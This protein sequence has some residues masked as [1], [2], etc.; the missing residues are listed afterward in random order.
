MARMTISPLLETGVFF[1][2]ELPFTDTE[3]K[4]T[5][6]LKDFLGFLNY[7]FQTPAKLTQTKNLSLADIR[8]INELLTHPLELDMKIGKH[9]YKLR[10]ED[11]TTYIKR[12]NCLA[13]LLHLTYHRK[14]KKYITKGYTGFLKLLPSWQF[15]HLLCAYWSDL[16]WG[17]FHPFQGYN[18]K[19]I[20]EVLQEVRP[21]LRQI[22]LTEACNWV[23]FE[24][25]AK[26]LA[27][28]FNLS[29]HDITGKNQEDLVSWQIETIVIRDFSLFNLIEKKTKK[30]E[31]GF[32]KVQSFHLTKLGQKVLGI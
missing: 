27:R 29:Y 4:N 9:L 15:F 2:S 17:Y 32:D 20:P 21:Y 7:L 12:L 5:P 25:F 22:L 23:D 18:D 3:V 13:E 19:N 28:I 16:N 6:L 31:H 30:D 24:F 1:S 10:S 8:A 26:N 11:A 14:G